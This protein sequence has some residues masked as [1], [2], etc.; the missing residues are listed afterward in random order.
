L[1]PA[2][3]IGGM[4]RS[5]TSLVAAMCQSA[6]LAIGDRL[7]EPHATNPL[8]HFEDVDFYRFHEHVLAENG[9]IPAGYDP[10]DTPPRVS[11]SLQQQAEN[12]ISDRRTTGRA[13]GWK[14]PRTV[15]F[16]DFWL[17]MLPEAKCLLVFRHPWQVADSLHRR[18]DAIFHN[19]AERALRLWH[20]YNAF[21]RDCADTH[22]ERVL[23]RSI[24]DLIADP[25]AVFQDIRT[26]LGIPLKDPLP[27]YRPELFASEKRPTLRGGPG[28]S[29]ISACEKLYEDLQRRAHA[30]PAVAAR[31]ASPP[32]KRVAVVIPVPRLP[33]QPDEEIS[34][35]QLRHH[36]FAYDSIAVAPASLDVD[37]L[38]LRVQRFPDACFTSVASYNQLC[39]TPA[40]YEAFRGYEYILTY[41]LDCLVF[42]GDLD[43]WCDRDWDYAGA[44]WFPDFSAGPE[45]GLWRVGNGGFSLR[46]VDALLHVLQRPDVARFLET[47]QGQ[48]DVF[49]SFEA[50]KYDPS[51]R[52]PEPTEAVAFSI[53]SNPRHCFALN[54]NALPFGCHYWNR[55]DRPFWAHF[56]AP[57][58]QPMPTTAL[59]A[60]NDTHHQDHEWARSLAERM[61]QTVATAPEDLLTLL[62]GIIGISESRLD[63]PPTQE[64]IEEAFQWLLSQPAPAE[65]VTWWVGRPDVT[66]RHLYRDLLVSEHFRMRRQRI[67]TG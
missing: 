31:T 16:L 39:L 24:D 34:F 47:Y 18:G 7:V 46:R 45:G 17:E 20:R 2:L 25:N 50:Q 9:R 63:G 30:G 40:F 66:L 41:Q 27:L 64:D 21:I 49:W 57:G 4:H 67:A 51:F 53:E 44:P 38:G 59:S 54:G 48:E 55:I 52:I 19:D 1:H 10:G 36:L 32:R 12:L 56:L 37:P 42:S 13:W 29:A 5:G 3:I 58:V 61:L 8:G 43:R 33:L 62:A 11:L 65:W 22:P 28:L 35:A 6:G 23:V 14:D 60:L 26:R 15:L